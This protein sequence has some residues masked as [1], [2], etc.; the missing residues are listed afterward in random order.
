MCVHACVCLCGYVCVRACLRARL[1]VCVPACT[2]TCVFAYERTSI[3]DVYSLMLQL[4]HLR[5]NKDSLLFVF[6]HLWL[7]KYN[8]KNRFRN[9]KNVW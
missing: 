6:A 5:E 9:I 7:L 4:G 1:I 8:I 2:G 3:N